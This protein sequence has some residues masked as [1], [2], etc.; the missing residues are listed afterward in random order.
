MAILPRVIS[1]TPMDALRALMADYA[2]GDPSFATRLTPFLQ[3]LRCQALPVVGPLLGPDG[4]P[5]GLRR[6]LLTHVG[7][8]DWPEWV[9]YIHAGL[10]AEADLGTFD[11]GC[12]ALG[13]LGIREAQASLKALQTARP[14]ADHQAILNRELA[15]YQAQ[16]PLTHYLSRVMEGSGNPRLAVQGAKVLSGLAESSDLPALG[17]ALGDGDEV[18]RHLVLRIIAGIPGIEP[19]AF[20]AGVA[21]RT[22]D[23]IL[24]NQTLLEL[25][26][27]THALARASSKAELRHLVCDRFAERA[28]AATTALA[29]A[30]NRPG[31]DLEG[32]AILDPLRSIAEGHSD[33]FLLESLGLL[34][35]NK[36]ARFSAFH[37]ETSD[38]AD[39]RQEQLS[40]TLDQAAEGLARR[41]GLG[42]LEAK[43]LVPTLARPFSLHLGGEAFLAAFLGMLPPSETRILDD[44]LA[45]TDHR[46]RQRGIELLGNREDNAFTPF[47]LKAMQDSIV[48]VGQLASRFASKLPSGLPA[49]MDQFHSGQFDQVRRAIW[50]FGENHT[51]AAAEPL[52]DFIRNDPKDE[53]LVEAVEA[54][55]NLR[56]PE[57]VATFM[58]LLHDGKPL[59]LQVSLARALGLVAQAPASLGLLQKAPLLKHPQ[60]LVLCLEGALRAFPGFETPLP[61]DHLPALLALVERCCDE[62]EGEGQRV[63]AMLAMLDLYVFDQGAYENL[64]DRFSDFLFDMRT[65]ANWDRDSNERVAAVVKELGR[66]SSSLALLAKKESDVRLLTQKLAESGARRTEH[67]LAL[68]EA[69]SDP[70]LI[71]RP[72]LASNLAEVVLAGLQKK[73]PDWKEVAYLCEIGGLTRQSRLVEPIRTIHLRAS[74]LGLKSSARKAL[75]NLG[76]TETDIN[77]KPPIRSILVLEPSAFFRKRLVSSLAAVGRWQVQEAGSRAEAMALLEVAPVDLL[78]SEAQDQEGDLSFWLEAQWNEGRCQSVLF[79]VSSRALGELSEAPWVEGTLFKPYPIEQLLRALKS[80]LA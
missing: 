67:L 35:E 5:K 24:D 54:L 79:S 52:L 36:V 1:L 60:V 46:R 41:V 40:T 55:A 77:R 44:I 22:T 39:A 8:F 53:L 12:T 29:E 76:L 48:D 14:G 32:T 50:A 47:F 62:R 3:T 75:L 49:L 7:R 70:E 13:T 26:Q 31:E 19:T 74:G 2:D 51:Q 30:L 80:D 17:E 63:P 71:L 21:D 4:G 72:E 57:A 43:D 78:L 45:D 18:V 28:P 59:A 58:E 34:I 11:E 64:K 38:Q 15:Q 73:V 42:F 25:L 10:L 9:S 69:L 16:Q 23:E 56:H 20:L 27:K 61:P 68:R 37:S 65:K 66:R 6:L 33:A